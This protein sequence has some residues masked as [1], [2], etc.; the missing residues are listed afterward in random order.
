[1]VI[2]VGYNCTQCNRSYATPVLPSKDF[3]VRKEGPTTTQQW[4]N[5]HPKL[6]L[7]VINFPKQRFSLI[8]IP[9]KK[10]PGH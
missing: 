3:L 5:I 8:H 6:T 1:M 7:Q 10:R 9:L 4:C 2:I